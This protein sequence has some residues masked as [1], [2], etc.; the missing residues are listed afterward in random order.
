[1]AMDAME[2]LRPGSFSQGLE[3]Y[4]R[5]DAFGNSVPMDLWS[6]LGDA[7]GDPLFAQRML[8]WSENGGYPLVT[9]KVVGSQLILRQRPYQDPSSTML[10]SIPLVISG[11]TAGAPDNIA[12]VV[13][14]L[15]TNELRV[16]LSQLPGTRPVVKAAGMGLYRV[17]YEDQWRDVINLQVRAVGEGD[18]VRSSAD[19]IQDAFGLLQDQRLTDPVIPLDLIRASAAH[20]HVHGGYPLYATWLRELEQLSILMQEEP[21]R[22]YDDYNDFVMHL[23]MDLTSRRADTVG[24]KARRDD[25]DSDKIIRPLIL[26]AQMQTGCPVAQRLMCPRVR[27]AL[28]S[29]WEVDNDMRPTLLMTAIRGD[30]LEWGVTAQEAFTSITDHFHGTTDPSLRHHLLYSLPAAKDARLLMAG[31][32]FAR[33]NLPAM[34]ATPST[35]PVQVMCASDWTAILNAVVKNPRGGARIAW[36]WLKPKLQDPQVYSQRVLSIIC[37]GISSQ[38]VLDD[39]QRTFGITPAEINPDDHP[40]LYSVQQNIARRAYQGGALCAWLASDRATRESQ[41]LP[42]GPPPPALQKLIVHNAKAIHTVTESDGSGSAVSFVVIGDRFADVCTSSE[43]RCALSSLRSLYPGAI[44]LDAAGKTITPGLIDA[45]GHLIGVGEETLK[46]SLRGAESKAECIRRVQAFVR[47]NPD[48]VQSGWILG[49][50]WDQTLWE[51]PDTPLPTKYDLDTAFSFPIW[52]SRVDGHGGWANSA[53]IRAAEAFNGEL[54]PATDPYGGQILRMP[55]GEPSGVFLDSAM[56]LIR[57]AI[58]PFSREV[59]LRALRQGVRELN[60]WGL[61]GVHDAGVAPENIQLYMESVDRGDFTLRNYVMVESNACST[62]D[63]RAEHFC[64]STYF[65]FWGDYGSH[66][67]RVHSVKIHLDGALGSYGAVMLE[68]YSHLPEDYSGD[69]R[70]TLKLTPEV[71]T[72]AVEHWQASGFQVNTHCIGDACDRLCIDAYERALNLIG[73]DGSAERHRIE[74]A[75]IF[76]E[77]DIPRLAPLNIIASMQP[78]HATSDSSW[79]ESRIGSER[80]A[81]AYAW[82]RILDTGARLALGSDFMVERPNPMLGI[83]A[84]VTRQRVVACAGTWSGVCPTAEPAGGWYPSQKLT[85]F[86]ALRGFTADAAYAAFDESQLGRIAPGGLADF[87]VL[88]RDI[89]DPESCPDDEILDAKAEQVYLG[90]VQIVG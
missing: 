4:L 44:E 83:Y 34:C 86:E 77:P 37:N 85:R 65:P 67:L 63:D 42:P 21:A 59:K 36:E 90:G 23:M 55:N 58:P 24:V 15:E 3:A 84:A 35:N 11:Q 57:P 89:M 20:A 31:I 27:Q 71:F 52:L 32:D 48:Q 73:S 14:W 9:A 25:S 8:T 12:P 18:D 6:N 30:C 38:D 74:H 53:A 47:D 10:W 28:A 26:D 79:A 5:M 46:V 68:P 61:T 33:A 7:L 87:L 69:P 39:M 56:D 43:G 54:L 22:C 40:A 17:D 75:Q 49:T 50:G 82:R 2:R 29:P 72:A 66:Q 76:S 81:G 64:A 80:I 88:D 45:H 62:A 13:I 51:G 19:A 60:K 41:V 78:T 1:M 70:G 16:P